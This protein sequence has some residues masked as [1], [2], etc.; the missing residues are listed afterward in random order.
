MSDT[1]SAFIGTINLESGGVLLANMLEA[2]LDAQPNFLATTEVSNESQD[3]RRPP[4][5]TD[6]HLHSTVDDRSSAAPSGEHRAPVCATRESPGV[7]LERNGDSD[8]GS[9]PGNVGNSDNGTG[10]LQNPGGRC[11]HETGR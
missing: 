7:G 6:L 8:P 4:E 10:G 2:W 3:L 9:G 11:F 5:Q 1:G